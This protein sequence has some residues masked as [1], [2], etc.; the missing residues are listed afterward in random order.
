[1][2][3][4]HRLSWMDR[5]AV[6]LV[7]VNGEGSV[8]R[9]MAHCYRGLALSYAIVKVNGKFNDTVIGNAELIPSRFRADI[10]FRFRFRYR[11]TDQIL[12]LARILE[13][14]KKKTVIAKNPSYLVLTRGNSSEMIGVKFIRKRNHP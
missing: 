14:I 9:V 8:Q 4:V 5:T 1:M 3:I 2:Q 6:K 10:R 13:E 11:P 7:V 12:T